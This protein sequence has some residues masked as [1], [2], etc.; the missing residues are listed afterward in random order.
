M[1]IYTDMK[2][3]ISGTFSKDGRLVEGC[4][5]EVLHRMMGLVLKK[6]ILGVRSSEIF[7]VLCATLDQGV[8]V[9]VLGPAVGPTLRSEELAAW[10]LDRHPMVADPSLFP[11]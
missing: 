1:F 4:E 5:C 11:M 2:T 7:Q 8:P 10:G 6:N 9:P 3:A